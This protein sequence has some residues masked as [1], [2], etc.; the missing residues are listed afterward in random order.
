MG[1]ESLRFVIASSAVGIGAGTAR[2]AAGPGASVV[3]SDMND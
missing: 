3:V 1:F 2:W